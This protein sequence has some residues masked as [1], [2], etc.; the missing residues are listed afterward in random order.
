MNTIL[1]T[2]AA[3][4]GSAIACHG[5][6]TLI[7]L[8][9]SL[10][11]YEVELQ[12][13]DGSASTRVQNGSADRLEVFADPFI[14]G[15]AVNEG[16][17]L[18][19]FNLNDLGTAA[20]D[21]TTIENAVLRFTLLSVS[22]QPDFGIEVWGRNTNAATAILTTDNNAG[23]QFGGAGYHR[24]SPQ[25]MALAPTDIAGPV[26]LS[27]D[28]TDFMD[29]RFQAL[30]NDDDGWVMIR[31]QADTPITIASGLSGTY[32]FAS[33]DHSNPA[34]RPELDLVLIPEPATA[35]LLLGLVTLALVYTRARRARTN[36]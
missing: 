31:L 16:R 34:Y 7:T 4:V 19:Q 14:P 32:A 24:I 27:V 17:T 6:S 20:S 11:D 3:L 23:G 15:F 30:R 9:G 29:E 1:K 36:G 26:E 22:A 12:T 28:I 2:V 21:A 25:G 8:S 5:A 10:A 18:F 33:A 35:A 13:I